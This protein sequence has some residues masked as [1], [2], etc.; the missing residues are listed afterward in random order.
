MTV[1]RLMAGE[2]LM[3]D[4]EEHE[5]VVIILGAEDTTSEGK[6]FGKTRGDGDYVSGMFVPQ[7]LRTTQDQRD[8][9][10]AQRELL[11]K[12]DKGEVRVVSA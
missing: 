5:R 8:K 11:R 3:L 2:G 9:R 6:L 4:E 7:H 1:K 12:L 10:Q